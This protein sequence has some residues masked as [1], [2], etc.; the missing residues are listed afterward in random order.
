MLLV[1]FDFGHPDRCEMRCAPL[2]HRTFE[3]LDAR[4][5]LLAQRLGPL[6]HP[7]ELFGETSIPARQLLRQ[8]LEAFDAHAG[9][10]TTSRCYTCSP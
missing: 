9:Q 7:A 2:A 4:D 1:G 3:V 6:S 8:L 10:C 5:G